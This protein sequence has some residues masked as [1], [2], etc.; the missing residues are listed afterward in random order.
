MMPLVIILKGIAISIGFS[1]AL[2]N[3]I[4][5]F[6]FLKDF[7]ITKKEH[8]IFYLLAGINI[9]SALALSIAFI[10]S[11]IYELSFV[12]NEYLVVSSI[13][14]AF[15]VFSEVFFRR[16]IIEKLIRYRISSKIIEVEKIV[17]L[18][19]IGFFLNSLS[20]VAW[21]LLLLIFQFNLLIH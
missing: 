18:R 19:K 3:D 6:K 10:I 21:L 1:S 9:F 14:L 13:L 20:F 2:I 11:I 15:V 4:L 12:N 16:V 17:I 8:K 7:K 5:T